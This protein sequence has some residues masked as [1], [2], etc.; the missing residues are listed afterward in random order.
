MN[1]DGDGD[2]DAS[3]GSY[4]ADLASDVGEN[5]TSIDPC[6]GG[7]KSCVG[8]L[9][10]GSNIIAGPTDF[11]TQLSAKVNV[12]ED[13]SNFDSLPKIFIEFGGQNLSIHPEG[14]VMKVPMPSWAK[15]ITGDGG[16]G[17]DGDGDGDG[18]SDHRRRRLWR[19][20]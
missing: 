8:I 19:R 2:G 20:W 15:A 11:M 14:Y 18:E 4:G 7:N 5:S 3:D 12:A 6:H 16:Y 1:G 10:T 13:C 17:G 9:D